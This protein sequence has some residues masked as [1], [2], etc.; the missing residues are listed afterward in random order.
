MHNFNYKKF[1]CICFVCLICSIRVSVY[2]TIRHTHASVHPDV[3]KYLG[4]LKNAKH[5]SYFFHFNI[6]DD[7]TP[8]ADSENNSLKPKKNRYLKTD[9][10]KLD[11]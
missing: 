10:I 8:S 6:V 5:Y 2:S 4:Y 1:K 3:P 11:Y 9:R 7:V